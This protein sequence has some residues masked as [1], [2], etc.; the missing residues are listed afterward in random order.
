MVVTRKRPTMLAE[1]IE[2]IVNTTQEKAD[3]EILVMYDIDD[4]STYGV[5]ENLKER[6]CSQ[7]SLKF[8][9]RERSSNINRD[10]YNDMALTKAEGKYII[11][12]N[13]DTKFIKTAWDT[14]ARLAIERYLVDRPDGIFYGVVD[15]REV[16]RKRN[17]NHWFSCFPLISKKSIDALGFFFDP[18]FGKDGADWDIFATYKYI[19]RVLDLR[20]FIIIEH[21]SVRS[22]RR[23]KDNLDYDYL[24]A[25]VSPDAGYNIGFNSVLLN[26]K[27]CEAKGMPPD[28]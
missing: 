11:A 14:E 9:T 8:F 13:D 2:S 5:V 7:M 17:E 16:E 1:L 24:P 23:P 22:G 19:G 4:S 20:P 15:D 27:I 10:Y 28:E 6:F 3:T 12:I 26:R 25:G 18:K 21:I